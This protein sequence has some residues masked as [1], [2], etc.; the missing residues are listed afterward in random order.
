MF[1]IVFL[2][3]RMCPLSEKEAGYDPCTAMCE[4]CSWQLSGPHPSTPFQNN[5]HVSDMF[6]R[7]LRGL[8]GLVWEVWRATLGFGLLVK[9]SVV[10]KNKCRDLP[11]KVF[12]RS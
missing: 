9:T 11:N 3:A 4:S 5:F 2:N 12:G 1:S 7:R 6:G 8:G 10:K